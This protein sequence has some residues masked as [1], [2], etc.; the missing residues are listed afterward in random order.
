MVTRRNFLT[1]GTLASAGITL[2]ANVMGNKN[3]D[4]VN[5]KN[6]ESMMTDPVRINQLVNL[7]SKYGLGGVGV[8][9]GFHINSN[10]QITQTLD[11]AWD[12]GVRYFDTSPFYGFGL[13]EH[14]FGHFLSEKD[15]EQYIVSTKIGRVFTPDPGFDIH[16][17][18][19]WKRPFPFKFH[20]DYSADGVRR[21]IEDSLQRMGLTSIDIVFIHDL[22]PD[23]GD[24]SGDKWLDYFEEARKGAIPELTKMREEGVI[25]AWGF[26]VNRPDPIVKAMEAGDP[27][28]MLVAIQYSLVDHKN[29]LNN[30]FPEMERK[31]VK[32][33]IGGPY[34]SG[35]LAGKPRF[36]YG[37]DIPEEMQ[38]KKSAIETIASRYN[39]NIKTASLQFCAA[40][41]A[42]ASVIPGASEAKQAIENV[43]SMSEK[44]PTDFWS[45]LK[46]EN[47]IE[48]NAP[49]P[50]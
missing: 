11:A 43:V 46:R 26:G 44:I 23:N 7:P 36:N 8:G 24:M 30:L 9:N 1:K 35:F 17:G 28:V 6:K 13:S 14:R 41:P 31:G 27:D 25:K 37:A 50:A 42:V 21:S 40:H 16:S 5:D 39:V 32:A 48:K 34:N 20:Y 33:I 3:L 19:L 29:A 49:V 2:S 10:S 4:T 47:L 38:R 45:E 12:A 22:S 15:R 18:G